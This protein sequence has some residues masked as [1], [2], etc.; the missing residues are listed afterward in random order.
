GIPTGTE[1][2]GQTLIKDVSLLQLL[3]TLAAISA[4]GSSHS[5]K[6]IIS[7]E[8]EREKAQTVVFSKK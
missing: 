8:N 2:K 4:S 1:I 6:L 7:D 5:F 3:S